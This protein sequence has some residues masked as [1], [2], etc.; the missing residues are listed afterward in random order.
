MSK[1]ISRNTNISVLIA[2]CNRPLQL[3]NCLNSLAK[4]TYSH[5]E[6]IIADQSQDDLSSQIISTCKL[7]NVTY[8]KMR[9]RNKAKALNEMIRRANFE[10]VTVTDDDCF[11]DRYWLQKILE[12]YK[13][14]PDIAGVFGNTYPYKP[15]KNLDKICPAIFQAKEVSIHE[16]PATAHFQK[17]G[18]GNNMSFRKSVILQVGLF[19]EW[20][21][22]GNFNQA[23]GEESELIFRILSANFKLM[24]NPEIV[25]YHDRWLT[26]ANERFLQT[27]YTSGLMAFHTY[28][29]FSHYAPYSRSLIKLLIIQ[30]F[31]KTYKRIYLFFRNIFKELIF[32]LLEI[33]ALIQGVGIGITMALSSK[34]FNHDKR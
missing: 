17:I 30:I 34:F 26:N 11:V 20:L 33:F 1:K 13:K 22:P 19:K 2:T 12:S 25:V 14:H 21:G 9:Q 3:K 32:F 4:N 28:Y 10:I 18:L 6:V 31:T 5:F 23:G 27:R 7:K 29:L 16:D 15:E 24:T 8:I